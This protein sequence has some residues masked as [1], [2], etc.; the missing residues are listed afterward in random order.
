MKKEYD[1]I[2]V[3]AGPAG[4]TAATYLSRAQLTCLVVGKWNLGNLYK[5]HTVGN[6]PGFS[7]DVSGAFIIEEMVKQAER[8]GTEFLKEE[9]IAI[10]KKRDKDFSVRTDTR[11]ELKSKSLILCPGKAYKMS[12]VKNEKELMGKGVSYCV[13]CDGLFFKNKKV[14][15]LGSKN[16]AAG[17]ALELL[18]YTKDITIFTNGRDPEFSEV[19]MKEIHKDNIKLRKDK[20]VEFKAHGETGFLDYVI[21][22]N[23]ERENFDGVFVALGMTSAFSFATRLGLEVIDTNIKVDSE[24]R[25]NVEGIWAAG[26]CTGTNAQAAVS[27]G[28]G[29]NASI[30]VIKY[31]KGKNIY[32]DYD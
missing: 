29:C 6:Y 8:F 26:D 22:D 27:A 3:G 32:L 28:A 16:L 13:T 24:G 1:C 15:V 12:N 5:A 9:V 2:I 23:G 17:E 14:A 4:L 20:V 21:F 11:T 7:K 25:T 18:I 10:D 30:S 31:I 19:L